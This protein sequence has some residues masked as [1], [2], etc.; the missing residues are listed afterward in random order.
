[1]KKLLCILSV[2]F[3]LTC[4]L[5]CGSS[6]E[7]TCQGVLE[8]Y[9]DSDYEIFHKEEDLYEEHCTCY[10]AIS[11]EGHED[12]IYFYFFTDEEAAKVYDEQND[13][14]WAASLFSLFLWDPTWIRSET[15]GNVVI[16]YTDSDLYKPFEDWMND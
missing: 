14:H 15:H 12:G 4:A 16:T 10:I 9:K 5:S 7:I 2:L 11:S 1:M 3:L 13:H 8:A 6:K